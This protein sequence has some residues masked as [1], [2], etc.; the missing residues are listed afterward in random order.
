M[1]GDKLY[2]DSL[3][4][5]MSPVERKDFSSHIYDPYST[6][7]VFLDLLKQVEDLKRRGG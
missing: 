1:A 4:G 3:T 5:K 2:F 6:T 7:N